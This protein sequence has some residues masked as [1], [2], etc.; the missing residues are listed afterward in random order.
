[1]VD[2]H[3]RPEYS[4]SKLAKLLKSPRLFEAM[5]ITNTVPAE[6]EQ[7]DTLGIGTLAHQQLLEP[8][9]ESIVR[10][11][12]ESVLSK[13]GA[14][15]TNAYRDWSE[16][17][18]GYVQLLQEDYELAMRCAEAVH[19]E[20]GP[21]I[22]NKAAKREHEVYWNDT[23]TELPMRAKLDLLVPTVAGNFIVDI[24]TAASLDKFKWQVKDGLWLQVAHYTAAARR[25]YED[26]QF[27]FCV[28]EKGEVCRVRSWKLPDREFEKAMRMYRELL[29]DLKRRLDANDWS[30]AGEGE[31]LELD[32]NL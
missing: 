19:K 15:N 8:H 25:F 14:R 11:V 24:K 27:F 29:D 3:S 31:L 21:L 10:V 30:E 4:R 23:A 13:S 12:P 17:N 20:I 16:Q 2:Y 32:I 22:N 1:M 18:A 6:I 9:L 7:N 26:V 5:F 28:V